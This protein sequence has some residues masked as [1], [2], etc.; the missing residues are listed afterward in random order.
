MNVFPDN[1]WALYT[2]G[3][4]CADQQQYPTPQGVFLLS[5][6]LTILS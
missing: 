6:A 3:L 1:H 2:L 4:I 5:R